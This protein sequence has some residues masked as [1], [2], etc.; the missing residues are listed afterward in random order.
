MARTPEQQI[1]Y[2]QTQVEQ[3][4]MRADSLF[5][6]NMAL[7]DNNDRLRTELDIVK[8]LFGCMSDEQRK[9]VNADWI[10]A[11]IN[12]ALEITPE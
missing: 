12:A 3:T 8:G 11:R 5:S 9:A 4:N 2:L 1:E 10:L 6:R 7:R